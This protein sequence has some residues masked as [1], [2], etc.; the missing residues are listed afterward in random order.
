MS[1]TNAQYIKEKKSNF[2][3]LIRSLFY[4]YIVDKSDLDKYKDNIN[5][6]ECCADADFTAYI[7][8]EIKPYERNIPAYVKKCWNQQGLNM[9]S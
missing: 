6:L 8:I 3:L 1:I 5:R 4:K 2:A 7:A 9:N